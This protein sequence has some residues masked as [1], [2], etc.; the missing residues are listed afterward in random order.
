MKRSLFLIIFV[1][2]LSA[3][4]AA[5]QSEPAPT[6]SATPQP[7]VIVDSPTPQ[8]SSTPTV[9]PTLTFTPT[10]TRTASPTPTMPPPPELKYVI[11]AE[12]D[13]GNKKLVI[14]QYISIPN[15]SSTVI[16]ELILVVPTNLFDNTFHLTNIAWED[17]TVIEEHDLYGS[18][19]TIPLPDSLKPGMVLNLWLSYELW[20][21]ANNSNAQ[22]GP[23]PFGYTTRQ[24][25][26]VDWYPFVPAYQDGKG[27]LVN[28]PW[29]Y[30]EFLVY[31]I[32]DFDVSITMINLPQP[33]IIAA[34]AP[35]TGDGDTHKYN[36]DD[37]RNFVWS[38]SP[39][40]EVFEA[41][42]NGTTILGYVFTPD[43][44]PGES[45]FN[46]TVDA[47]R[48]YSDFYGSYP[49]PMLSMVE[50]DFDHGMEYQSLYF[51]NKGFFASFDGASGSFL[52]AIA[53]HE[54]SHQ[55]W[56]GLVANDQALEP[57]LDEALSTYSEYLFYEYYYPQDI[58]GFWWPRRVNPYNPAG[59]VNNSIY[60]ASGYR[61]YRDAVYLQGAKFLIDLRN[62]MGNE[63]FYAFL[64]DYTATYT[65]RVATGN[66][67]FKVLSKYLNADIGP[68]L[69]TYF[70]R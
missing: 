31:P 11:W 16:H 20:L 4:L 49:H 26:L 57:W 59:W 53:A 47:F 60:S 56:Y 45:A 34:S 35:D 43:L 37:G 14:D 12:M 18:R 46:A 38:Y 44:V 67:F 42:V 65:N 51:L 66:D 64:K 1:I 23:N 19:L 41:E 61:E 17:G 21:P 10:F 29:A 52:V 70:L 15:N 25:N 40:Y 3:A 50:G 36:L 7:T 8:P 32:A 68:L 55:W 48:L 6:L 13:V 58:D 9:V 27:W 2:I 39:Y 28:D 54:T 30:G 63:A 24:V 22:A 62:I 5:C 69:E 33:M